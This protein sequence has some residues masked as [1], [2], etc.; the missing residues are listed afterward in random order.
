MVVI[1]THSIGLITSLSRVILF[2]YEWCLDMPNLTDVYLPHA[3]RYKNDVTIVGS[4][5]FIPL[6]RIDI[7]AL[8]NCFWS[9]RGTWLLSLCHT[10]TTPTSI[11]L[12]A[13]SA[14]FERALSLCEHGNNDDPH[15]K[16]WKSNQNRG[17]DNKW[18]FPPNRLKSTPK[19]TTNRPHRF[20]IQI[21]QIHSVKHR[22]TTILFLSIPT[23]R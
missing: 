5:H 18:S 10:L 22:N 7:G 16:W 4:T 15:L 12:R 20:L 13:R 3:F 11:R 2:H 17:N 14:A 9:P 8:R 23:I 19:L 1:V 6:S 21:S